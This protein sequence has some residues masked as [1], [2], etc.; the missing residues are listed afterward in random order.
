MSPLFHSLIHT[1][2]QSWQFVLLFSLSYYPHTSATINHLQAPPP[3]LMSMQQSLF[4]L[5]HKQHAREK[6]SGA[7]CSILLKLCIVLQLLVIS[8]LSSSLLLYIWTAL[9]FLCT[10]VLQEVSQCVWRALIT[11]LSHEWI[12]G[13][14]IW[15]MDIWLV[16]I[17]SNHASVFLMG[18]AIVVRTV[19]PLYS[20][21]WGSTFC[22]VGSKFE[23]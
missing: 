20:G 7:V 8:M 3:Q 22:P 12:T 15:P 16:H 13:S 2:L 5:I 18:G 4:F 21:H 14:Y 17:H 6:K 11:V 19:K 23:A 1:F 10:W 9:Y